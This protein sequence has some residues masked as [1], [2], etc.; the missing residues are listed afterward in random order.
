MSKP[1][2]KVVTNSSP[3]HS[4]G[5]ARDLS[6]TNPVIV[7]PIG[8]QRVG[9]TVFLNA[10][11]QLA[12]E[13]GSEIDVWNCDLLNKSHSLSTFHQEAL[14]PSSGLMV[15][16]RNWIES[17]FEAQVESRRDA[18]LDVGGGWTAF[19]NLIEETPL[20]EVLEDANLSLV[21][22]YILGT[23]SG[24]L[25]YL[26]TLRNV[27]MFLP[28]KSLIVLNEGLVASGRDPAAA[29]ESIRNHPVVLKAMEAGA[30]AAFMPALS[31]MAAVTDR[32]LSF[33]DFADGKQVAG[34]P[35]TS[36][37]DRTRVRRWFERDM[38]AFF[39]TIPPGWMPRVAQAEVV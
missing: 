16:Q 3:T 1:P 27:K 37:F 10:L 32:G 21:A 6:Q 30:E 17:R 34:F 26:D 4:R 29:F 11:L 22:V 8:R 31:C 39:D 13:H 19:H 35:N 15:D 33:A 28:K 7:T 38:P 18:V 23:E 14:V 9:K 36:M 20:V 12:R 24:D 2:L 25:D 5:P